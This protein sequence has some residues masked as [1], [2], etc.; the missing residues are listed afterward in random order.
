M[1]AVSMSDLPRIRARAKYNRGERTGVR[2]FDKT[3][4]LVALLNSVNPSK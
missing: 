3:N 1:N 2:D 4:S